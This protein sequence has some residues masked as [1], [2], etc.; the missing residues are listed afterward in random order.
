[1]VADAHAKGFLV[2][3]WPFRAENFFLPTDLRT[4]DPTDPSYLAQH[5]DWRAEYEVF[6]ATGLDGTFSDQPDLA[7]AAREAVAP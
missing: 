6:S 4:G 5:G 3:A 1:V 2:H 7:V